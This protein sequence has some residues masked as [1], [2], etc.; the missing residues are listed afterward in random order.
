M[1]EKDRAWSIV[2][3]AQS[4]THALRGIRIFFITTPNALLQVLAAF[5]VIILGFYFHISEGEWLAVILTIGLVF[6]AE[7]INT[8][9]EIDI[10]LTS[11]EFHPYARDTKDVAAGAVFFAAL[12]SIIVGLIVFLPH[13]LALFL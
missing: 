10:N 13:I 7:I 8:A 6:I 2:S 1:R 4:F 5:A 12:V 3:R 9:I 11:P